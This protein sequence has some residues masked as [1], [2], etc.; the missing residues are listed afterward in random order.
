[1]IEFHDLRITLVAYITGVVGVILWRVIS[2][3]LY[4][5]EFVERHI[6]EFL[7]TCIPGVILL[8]LAFPSLHLLY[9][10]E[11][12]YYSNIVVKVIGHQ[13]Y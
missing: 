11:D 13:W 4:L 10:L 2:G 7:W 1:M 8:V 12:P 3:R 6:V 9:I 5:G